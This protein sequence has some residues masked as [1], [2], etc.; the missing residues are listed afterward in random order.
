MLQKKIEKT[1][2]IKVKNIKLFEMALTHRSAVNEYKGVCEHNER[3]EFLGDAVLELVVTEYLYKKYPDLS[4][5]VLTNLRSSLVKGDTLSQMAKELSFGK[6]L[7]LSKGEELFG[8]REKSSLLANTVE[9][10]IGAIYLDS[11]LKNVKVLI[12]KNLIPKLKNIIKKGSYVDSK[13]Q[14]QQIAQ[15]KL[16]KTPY[17]KSISEIGPDHDKIFEVRVFVGEKSYG[18]GK[19][20]SKQEAQQNAAKNALDNLEHKNEK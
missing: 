1:L 14:F 13:S 2:G 4:E 19:G 17:Y 20:S 10:L 3:L 16:K 6:M 8:G 18:Q 15:S 7:K 9:A 5:G 12:E 11:G